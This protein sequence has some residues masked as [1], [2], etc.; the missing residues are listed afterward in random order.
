MKAQTYLEA[1]NRTQEDKEIA[2][3]NREK[4]TW[5]ILVNDDYWAKFYQ[6]RQRQ[7]EKFL[8]ALCVKL[9]PPVE[10]QQRDILLEACKEVQACLTHFYEDGK[11][12]PQFENVAGVLYVMGAV[13]AQAIFEIEGA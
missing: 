11:V 8:T 3:S 12:K 2:V 1:Y 9:A 4:N 7:G 13:T 10:R 6:K 5:G